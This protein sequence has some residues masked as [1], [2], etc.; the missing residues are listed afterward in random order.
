MKNPID[1]LIS[2]LEKWNRRQD[3]LAAWEAEGRREIRTIRQLQATVVAQ[4]ADQVDYQRRQAEALESIAR[5]LENI[6]LETRMR[7]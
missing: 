3:E 7:R 1:L 2:L 4:T 5:H 6:A